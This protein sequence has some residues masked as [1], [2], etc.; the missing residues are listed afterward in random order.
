[1]QNTDCVRLCLNLKQMF[2]QPLRALNP[3]LF[4]HE[5]DLGL[6]EV[7]QTMI[8]LGVAWMVCLNVV[9]DGCCD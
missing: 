9:G 3:S 4:A 5:L 1:M 8:K 7:V 6:V 2:L